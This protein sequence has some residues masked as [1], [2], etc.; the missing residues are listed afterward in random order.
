MPDLA[1]A[2]DIV[3]LSNSYSEM[4]G[5]NIK[6][7]NAMSHS[8]MVSNAKLSCLMV[9]PWRTLTNSSSMFIANGPGDEIRCRINLSRSAFSRLKSCLWSEREISLRIKSMVYQAVARSIL[10]YGC[11][12][13]PVRVA[14][15]GCWRSLKITAS[16]AFYT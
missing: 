9:S 1:N 15:E 13:W 2:N 10:L 5:M 12:T 3:L 4:Q 16:A 7:T 11:E 6:D 14:D 8:S